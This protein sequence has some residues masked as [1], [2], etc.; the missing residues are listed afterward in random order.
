VEGE[1]TLGILRRRE[2]TLGSFSYEVALPGDV[3]KDGVEADLVEG[4][5]TVR[6][7]K[8]ERH[9]PGASRSAD[10]LGCGNESVR[11]PRAAPATAQR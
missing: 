1:G 11:C 4:V 10:R 9:R 5:L 3:N 7:P 8:P 6:L 2:R